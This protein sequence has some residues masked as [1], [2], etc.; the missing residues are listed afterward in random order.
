MHE[1]KIASMN[2]KIFRL[3][4][5]VPVLGLSIGSS[6]AALNYFFPRKTIRVYQPDLCCEFVQFRA[7]ISGSFPHRKM[8]IICDYKPCWDYSPHET[9]WHIQVSD[10][11]CLEWTLRKPNVVHHNDN[12]RYEKVDD[13]KNVSRYLS[14][15]RYRND[16]IGVFRNWEYD[17]QE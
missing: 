12:I 2:V 7:Q 16:S 4:K 8:N 11:I 3:K 14:L 15:G 17:E 5:I 10:D 9:Q 1:Q 13:L 6:V